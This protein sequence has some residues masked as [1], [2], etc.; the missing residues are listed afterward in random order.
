MSGRLAF[1]IAVN[2]HVFK[3]YDRGWM[4]VM[5]R[6]VRQ[7]AFLVIFDD[8]AL[9]NKTSTSCIALF[10]AVGIHQGCE[11]YSH[12]RARVVD[13]INSMQCVSCLVDHDVNTNCCSTCFVNRLVLSWV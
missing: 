13:G 8:L 2:L 1:C 7:H 3:I 9:Q 4:G 6:A 12:E 5:L 11:L 10:L